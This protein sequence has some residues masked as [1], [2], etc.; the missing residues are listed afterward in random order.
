[1]YVS[2]CV[3]RG[4]LGGGG[5]RVGRDDGRNLRVALRQFFLILLRAAG[6]GSSVWKP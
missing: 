5:G 4:A 2:A 3:L 1:M 6:G